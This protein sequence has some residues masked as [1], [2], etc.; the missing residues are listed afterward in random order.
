MQISKLDG[1]T[2]YKVNI[3]FIVYIMAI[4]YIFLYNYYLYNHVL[5][6]N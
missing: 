4:L 6:W 2:Q 1:W 5:D 3:Q